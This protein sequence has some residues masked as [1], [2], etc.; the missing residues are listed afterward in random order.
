MPTP[1]CVAARGSSI[2]MLW[3]PDGV[4]VERNATSS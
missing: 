4:G 3:I 2:T 1:F